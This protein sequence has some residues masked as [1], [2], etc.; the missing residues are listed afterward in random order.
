MKIVII[1]KLYM[2][3]DNIIYL[4]NIRKINTIKII[5]PINEQYSLI[6]NIYTYI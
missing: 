1:N 4:L 3:N 2:K 5:S 6:D